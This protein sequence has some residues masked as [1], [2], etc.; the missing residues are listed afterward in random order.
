MEQNR[1]QKKKKNT[2][3]KKK[4]TKRRIESRQICTNMA[5]WYL[6]NMQK[7]LNGGKTVFS[8]NNV[9]TIGYPYVVNGSWPKPH[10]LL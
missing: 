2:T 4:T 1:V 7:Q 10:T 3:G 9:G 5:N 6:T 8:T